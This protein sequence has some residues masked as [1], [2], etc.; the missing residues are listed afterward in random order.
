MVASAAFE[1]VVA[2]TGRTV[3]VNGN[4]GT[5]HGTASVLFVMGGAV[6]GGRV[7]GDWP[8]LARL[9]DDRDL[10]MSTDSRAVMKG[11]LRDHFG[12]DRT[13]LGAR[14]FPGT[15]GLGAFE[16]LLRA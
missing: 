8:G 2:V 4:N 10:R 3:A 13:V 5:D 1:A 15:A 6:K 11:V 16:G 12:L 7:A 9:Q 14:V